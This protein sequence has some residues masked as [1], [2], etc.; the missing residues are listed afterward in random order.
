MK[1]LFALTLVVSVTP[2][3]LQPVGVAGFWWNGTT[4]PTAGS[5]YSF[6]CAPIPVSVQVGEPVVLRV[7]GEFTYPYLLGMAPSATRCL[8]LPGVFNSVLL[9]DPVTIITSGSLDQ[10]SPLLVWP[11]GFTELNVILPPS[12]PTGATF[13]LQAAA[14]SGG[15][16]LFQPVLTVAFDVTVL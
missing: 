8:S 16:G 10:T 14:W 7:V 6:T 13:S 12:V 1:I 9:D 3:Q 11:S 5:T 2:A 15:Q 4:T